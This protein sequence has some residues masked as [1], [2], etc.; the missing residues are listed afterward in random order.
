MVGFIWNHELAIPVG[1]T[2]GFKREDII[3]DLEYVASGQHMGKVCI[4]L[5]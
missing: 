4:N 3:A 1:K 5:D 2:F